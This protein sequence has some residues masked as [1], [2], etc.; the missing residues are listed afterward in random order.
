MTV[1]CETTEA[2]RD[3]GRT[4]FPFGLQQVADQFHIIF[5]QRRSLRG[6]RLSTRW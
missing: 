1:A 5:N 3:I 4:R 6:A 2:S